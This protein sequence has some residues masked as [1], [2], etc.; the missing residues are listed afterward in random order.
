MLVAK[1]NVLSAS[2]IVNQ[3]SSLANFIGPVIGG[4]LYGMW[5]IKI[6]LKTSI[7]CFV[8][9]AIM[10][11]FINIP[12][13]KQDRNESVVRTV[14]NDLSE[15]ILFLKN[16]KRVFIRV[17]LVIAGL[18][19]VLSSMVTIG[20]PVVV[21][22]ILTMSD[23]MLGIIQGLLAV[24]GIIGGL[25]TFALGKKLRA[26]KGYVLLYL[27][28]GFACLMGLGMM[29]CETSIQK[30][31]ILAITSVAITVVSTMFSIQMLAIVQT[32]TPENMVG[33]VVASIM[34]FVMC[35]Q[36]VGQLVYGVLFEKCHNASMIMLV[37]GAVSLAIAAY[38]RRI[39]CDL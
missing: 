11:I 1:D 20:V 17:S 4:M 7:L 22:D 23:Q 29:I 13:R 36:P 37:A 14:K 19:L 26:S 32:E 3:I 39:L 5:G 18:N 24:G 27:C 38:S 31:I 33:K 30:Y 12:F 9:S 16:E 34:V 35:V 8:C 10:E 15:S 25:L 6:I 2:A 21:V 28:A